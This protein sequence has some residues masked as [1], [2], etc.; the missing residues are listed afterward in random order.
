M[1]TPSRRRRHLLNGFVLGT[2]ATPV[3]CRGADGQST[4]ARNTIT[5]RNG[6]LTVRAITRGG[7]IELTAS[8]TPHVAPGRAAVVTSFGVTGSDPVVVRAYAETDSVARLLRTI[9][10][11]GPLAIQSGPTRE[12]RPLLHIGSTSGF[13]LE[14]LP[15]RAL[16]R[17]SQ[18]EIA[19]RACGVPVAWDYADSVTG[20]AL[21]EMLRHAVRASRNAR[22]SRTT[23]LLRPAACPP[24]PIRG[25]I[26]PLLDRSDGTRAVDVDATLHVDSTGT[27]VSADLVSR[28]PE[29]A[30]RAVLDS[31]IRTW[32][33][34]PARS[35]DGAPQAAP[36]RV[37]VRYFDLEA[38]A[39]SITDARM[40]AGTDNVQYLIIGHYAG[41]AAP[42]EIVGDDVPLHVIGG[43]PRNGTAV[44]IVPTVGGNAR[45]WLAE[46]E[47]LQ[48]DRFSIA[49]DPRGHGSS[50][51][52]GPYDIGTQALDLLA[53]IEH[54]GLER[55]IVVGEGTGAT[56]AAEAAR[57]EPQRIA[58][59]VLVA[60]AGDYPSSPQGLPNVLDSVRKFVAQTDS[61]SPLL[62]YFDTADSPLRAR[63]ER[64]IREARPQA[65]DGTISSAMAHDFTASL[66]AYPGPTLVIMPARWTSNQRRP[67]FGADSASRSAHLSDVAIVTI[68]ANNRWLHLTNPWD[69]AGWVESFAYA[70]D[71]RGKP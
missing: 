68:T 9:D 1:I 38:E 55:A 24:R 56:I 51:A 16:I 30:Y 36:V 26:V 62:R 50:A 40:R 25:T 19:A 39:D 6:T 44:V 70:V 4:S 35:F 45:Q 32:Q 5:L 15:M 65:I 60:P 41:A 43:G 14:I 29:G 37:R 47:I 63:V 57:R 64:D 27:V 71:S 58:G 11:I 66:V 61:V 54:A 7:A 34:E 3:L 13:Q 28:R 48:Q 42:R 49:Y 31:A 18:Y 21:I 52:Q 12:Q 33:F 53:L 69:V 17:G 67:P 23:A 2:L 59:L 8:T 20:A 10:S 22:S 46:L